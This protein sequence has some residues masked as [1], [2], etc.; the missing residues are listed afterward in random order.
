MQPTPGRNRFA[1]LSSPDRNVST[2][3]SMKNKAISPITQQSQPK[4]AK[5]ST[6]KSPPLSPLLNNQIPLINDIDMKHTS[7]TS[8]SPPNTQLATNY[9]PSYSPNG[10]FFNFVDQPSLKDSNFIESLTEQITSAILQ[11]VD[12]QINS[13]SSLKS[14]IG[15]SLFKF[16]SPCSDDDDTY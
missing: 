14:L 2:S 11:S 4:K 5:Q 7:G 15:S 8:H 6:G 3:T 10:S 13:P 16:L 1:S 12:S 9:T